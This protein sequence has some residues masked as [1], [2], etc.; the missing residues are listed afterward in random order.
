MNARDDGL[1]K[2]EQVS[3]QKHRAREAM[4]HAPSG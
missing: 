1:F 2:V 4:P 3:A